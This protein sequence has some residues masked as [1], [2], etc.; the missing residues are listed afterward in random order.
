MC[1]V[2]FINTWLFR[3]STTETVCCD[4][5]L[6]YKSLLKTSLI[7]VQHLKMP[8]V[9]QMWSDFVTGWRVYF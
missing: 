8:I 9:S 2:D 5:M 4:T 6:T 3:R 1:D 7:V